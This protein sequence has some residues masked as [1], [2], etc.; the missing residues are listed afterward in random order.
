MVYHIMTPIKVNSWNS[1]FF[2][3]IMI[4][5]RIL[6]TQFLICQ[7]ELGFYSFCLTIVKLAKYKYMYVYPLCTASLTTIP[8][9]NISTTHC[10]FPRLYH[11]N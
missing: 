5:Q 8:M 3:F 9:Y 6:M 7:N 10:Y 11:I 1:E 2:N 4:F